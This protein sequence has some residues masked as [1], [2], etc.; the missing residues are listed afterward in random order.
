MDDPFPR[1]LCLPIHIPH[2]LAQAYAPRT[3]LAE[4]RTLHKA[5]RNFDGR[6][7]LP[8]EAAQKALLTPL[9]NPPPVHA[10]STSIHRTASQWAAHP[11]T[12]LTEYS[13]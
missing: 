12:A 2:V 9:V 3:H 11:T 10:S 7:S 4:S 6:P 1:L 8:V 13:P 5:C